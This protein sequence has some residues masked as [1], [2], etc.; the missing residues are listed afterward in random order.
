MVIQGWRTRS[1]GSRISPSL[2]HPTQ[3]RAK[4][5]TMTAAKLKV[6]TGD[7]GDPPRRLEE[8]EKTSNMKL[9]CYSVPGQ[10]CRCNLPAYHQP[11]F[12]F[13]TSYLCSHST[14]FPSQPTRTQRITI[15]RFTKS[16][17]HSSRPTPVLA[18]LYPCQQLRGHL[19]DTITPRAQVT[20]ASAPTEFPAS[21]LRELL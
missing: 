15:F 16:I 20:M 19:C 5:G 9:F 2:L 4:P 21:T 8:A 17:I 6:V 3:S 10:S 12:L 7:C 18:R 1:P 11:C 14:E 13:S